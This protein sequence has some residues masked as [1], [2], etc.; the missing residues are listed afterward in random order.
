MNAGTKKR[1]ILNVVAAAIILGLFGWLF[2]T[3]FSL[4]GGKADWARAW[5]YREMLWR[6]WINTLWISL[7]ALVGAILFGGLFLAGQKSS[8]VVVRWTCRGI[9]EFVRD[10]PLLVHLLF[11]YF[12]IFAPLVSRS[13]SEAGWDDKFWIGVLLLSIF[14]GA[15]LGEILRGGVD[16]IPKAQ[17]ESARAV[18][19][20]RLQTIRFVI[21]PQALRRVLPAVAG[22]FVSLIKDSSLECDR[23]F[24]V[25]LQHTW[26]YL[27]DLCRIGRVY[28]AGA[29]LSDSDASRG[30]VFPLA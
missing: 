1:L 16:S 15:Y 5:E 25:F 18:G 7:L 20:D 13:M 10:T 21:I 28:P 4:L 26:V 24:R 17:W 14:E 30:V 8:L 22:L 19:F 11:G 27:S 3:V 6:G 29:W 2:T 12:V 23:C 9:L